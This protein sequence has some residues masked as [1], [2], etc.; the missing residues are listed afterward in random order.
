MQKEEHA[1][2]FDALKTDYENLTNEL[3]QTKQV[4]DDL[5]TLLDQQS[6]EETSQHSVLTNSDKESQTDSQE[7]ETTVV[8]SN[9]EEYEKTIATLKDELEHLRKEQQEEIDRLRQSLKEKSSHIIQLE[10]LQSESTSMEKQLHDELELKLAHIQQIEKQLEEHEQAQQ[11]ITYQQ[12][13]E[14]VYLFP[15]ETV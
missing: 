13:L 14:T 15:Y 7:L 3:H 12:S 9:N 1:K 4:K 11:T 8:T 2:F 10:Q 5:Q 6:R